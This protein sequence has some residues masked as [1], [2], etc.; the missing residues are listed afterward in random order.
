MLVIGMHRGDRVNLSKQINLISKVTLIWFVVP[1]FDPCNAGANA[2]GGEGDD[3]VGACAARATE[4][5]GGGV[6]GAPY[7]ESSVMGAVEGEGGVKS[8]GASQKH[9]RMDD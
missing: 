6:G 3:V 8:N 5:K 9:A 7:L 4:S 1:A 2:A